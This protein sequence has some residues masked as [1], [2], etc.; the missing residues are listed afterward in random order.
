MPHHIIPD[1]PAPR[2]QAQSPPAINKKHQS[3][4][5]QYRTRVACVLDFDTEPEPT[6][7]SQP[8]GAVDCGPL[9]PPAFN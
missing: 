8:Q 2:P 7:T 4:L 5:R 3:R 9:A 1:T 6:A